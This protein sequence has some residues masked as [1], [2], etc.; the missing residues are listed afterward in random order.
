LATLNRADLANAFGRPRK[1]LGQIGSCSGETVTVELWR[2]GMD[3]IVVRL[4]AE[5]AV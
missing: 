2:G 4:T 3:V 5:C 1:S